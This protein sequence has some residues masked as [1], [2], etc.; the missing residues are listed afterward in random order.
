MT[1]VGWRACCRNTLRGFAAVGLTSG[2]QIEEIPVHVTAGRAW[3]GL[4]ARPMVGPDGAGALIP[5]APSPRPMILRAWRPVETTGSLLGFATI[6]LPIGLVPYDCPEHVSHG[7]PWAALPGRPILDDGRHA[8]DPAR[9]GKRLWAPLGKWRDLD[10]AARWW[11][12]VELVRGAHPSEF[13][14]AER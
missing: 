3:A 11:K 5:S 9:P 12:R 1:L 4:P 7:H 6:E 8:E 13:D 2:L 14:E 10:I